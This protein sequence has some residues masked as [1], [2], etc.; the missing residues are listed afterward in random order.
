M[1]RFMWIVFILFIASVA[2]GDA[3]N[4]LCL[5]M[6]SMSYYP[7][8]GIQNGICTDTCD[9]GNT[10]IADSGGAYCPNSYVTGSICCCTFAPPA[11]PPPVT[12]P[13]IT[14]ANSGTVVQGTAFN[15]Q[16]VATNSPD[17][18]GATGLPTGLTINTATGLISGTANSLFTGSIVLTASNSAGTGTLVYALT[19]VGPCGAGVICGR[20]TT[21]ENGDQLIGGVNVQ[22]K[23]IADGQV[24][25]I[26]ISHPNAD[27][28]GNNYTLPVTAGH[29]YYVTAAIDRGE[30]SA[31]SFV[32]ASGSSQA[33]F[34]IRGIRSTL[35][36]TA[37]PGA[38]LLFTQ[39]A[40]AGQNAPKIY[41]GVSNGGPYYSKS[42][43]PEGTAIVQVPSGFSYWMTCWQPNN[44]VPLTFT[45][46]QTQINGGNPL[47]PNQN[48]T[49]S[50][51]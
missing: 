50:C 42:A 36:V 44:T 46:S 47:M 25:S 16:I 17:T 19:V 28:S 12:A 7:Y 18:Y 9:Y 10:L 40:Y 4:D 13:V 38:Y 49:G 41:A 51:N 2:Y 31:P 23:D 45:R 48:L 8:N 22:A 21:I 11:T 24:A 34:H 26:G 39:T 33:D 32:A 1:K 43:S 29:R 35:N 15:Y 5:S 3:C 14:S 6:T 37:R 27:A 20:I 30:S